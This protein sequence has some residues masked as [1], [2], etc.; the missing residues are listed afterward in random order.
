MGATTLKVTLAGLALAIVGGGVYLVAA[1]TGPQ[2]SKQT[3]SADMAVVNKTSFEIATT[4]S[5]DLQAKTQLELRS[6]L[7]FEASLVELAAEGAMVKAGDLLFRLNTDQ[8]QTQIDEALLRV[9]SAKADLV[10]ADNSYEIQKSENESKIRQAQ[11]KHEVA[12]LALEQWDKGERVQKEKDIELALDKTAKDL[13]RLIE[14]Y[15][16]S[17][18]LNKQGFL[19]RD[20]MQK[21]EISLREA[22]AARAKAE[23]EQ[24]T[25]MNYQKPKDEKTKKSDVEEA[26][27]ELSRVKQQATIQ[28]AIKDAD[29]VNRRRTLG[30]HEDKL[31]K[32]QR[33]I[34]AATVRAPQDGLVVYANSAGRN[35]FDD[36][37]FAVGRKVRPQEPLIVLPDT[38]EMV[39]AVRVHESL[40]G[41]IRPGQLAIVKIDAYAG[42]SFLGTVDSIG[43]MA[44]S[45]GRWSD[46]NRREYTVKI[47]M[48]ET[49]PDVSLKPAMRCEAVITL[50]RVED[51]LAVPLQAVFNDDMVRFVYVPRGSK[52][53]RVPV[54]VGRRSDTRAEII[55]GI[56]EGERVLLREPAAGEIISAPWDESQL[57]LVGLKMSP[58]GKPVPLAGAS[59]EGDPTKR[60]QGRPPGGGRGRPGGGPDG[61]PPEGKGP[62]AKAPVT[63][64]EVK[65]PE[66][67]GE[68]AGAETKAPVT[69][70]APAG[71]AKPAKQ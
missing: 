39:A 9:E 61:R 40:A 24:N 67:K 51:V 30:L 12:I 57:K 18:E 53:A 31:A 62:E 37:P 41:R 70:Q 13:E 68:V 25:Y 52:Y 59:S 66:A 58:E 6:E 46:P 49:G 44:E 43:V 38:G 5:G 55:A 47:A 8:I 34:V 60:R 64:P 63:A 10:A 14:K 17:I 28:L 71:D 4:A 42:R 22:R 23:L 27:A 32:L 2:T 45:Q 54:Q 16:Q 35:F 3:T 48:D 50:G 69:V 36:S 1:G 26:E 65:T 11:L 7:D 19:S 21:D 15:E 56:A 20:E 33:Q 29:R